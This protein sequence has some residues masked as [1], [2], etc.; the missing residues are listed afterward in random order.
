MM[1]RALVV[2]VLI[3]GLLV[4]YA[5][6]GNR[7]QAQGQPQGTFSADFPFA[8]GDT[9]RV[10]FEV[11][12]RGGDLCVIDNFRGPFVMCKNGNGLQ[13]AFNSLKVIKVTQV[14]AAQ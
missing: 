8:V 9:V 4:G 12:D 14:K 6:G 7:L 3:C 13:F 5:A 2:A 11:E 10:L 1:N